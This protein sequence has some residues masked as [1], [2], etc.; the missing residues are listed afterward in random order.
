[1]H[2]QQQTAADNRRRA[3][4]VDIARIQQ[5]SVHHEQHPT[6]GA[7]TPPMPWHCRPMVTEYISYK[8]P[9]VITPLQCRPLVSDNISLKNSHLPV[10]REVKNCSYIHIQIQINAKS[11]SLL[12][13]HPLPMPLPRSCMRY[14]AHR[15]NDRTNEQTNEWRNERSHNSAS[16]GDVT[17]DSAV[18]TTA[19]TILLT[20]SLVIN[21]A[22]TA[23]QTVSAD[24][25][26]T[27]S[28]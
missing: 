14:P 4:A 1:M 18:V 25:N 22:C 5:A 12:E 24:Y 28:I 3:D 27:F 7:Q 10:L 15:Q 11:Q 17:S 26:V 19:T 13:D 23:L 6:H 16:P 2:A 8:M 9:Y 21:L 20:I